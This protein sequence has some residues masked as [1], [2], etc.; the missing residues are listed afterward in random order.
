MFPEK[1]MVVKPKITEKAAEVSA[2][3]IHYVSDLSWLTYASVL[4]YAQ[5]LATQL[6]N[7]HPKDMVDIQSFIWSIA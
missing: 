6:S 3:E 2:F 7:L 5:F 1:Y 4:K